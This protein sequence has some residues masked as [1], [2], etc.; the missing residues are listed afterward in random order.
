MIL[1]NSCYCMCT[2]FPSKSFES[3]PVKHKEIKISDKK[4]MSPTNSLL[5]GGGA[6]PKGTH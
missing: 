1:K 6:L 3:R 4:T 5:E 2:I